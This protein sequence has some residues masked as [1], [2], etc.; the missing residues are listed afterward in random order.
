M[1]PRSSGHERMMSRPAH[2]LRGGVAVGL[3]METD[4]AVPLSRIPNPPLTGGQQGPPM[5][6]DT[7]T[8]PRTRGTGGGVRVLIVHADAGCREE[9][10]RL[11]QRSD[12]EV[13]DVVP[14]GEAAISAAKAFNPDLV[15]IGVGENQPF[16]A[17]WTTRRLAAEVPG[18]R[19][20]IF[21]DSDAEPE[22]AGSL[23]D[24][25]AG[26]VRV[27]GRA[28]RLDVT[29]RIAIAL[30]AYREVARYEDGAA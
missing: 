3:F 21:G 14:E 27:D 16:S 6:A 28:E 15:L 12:I 11:L 29:V 24:G 23:V 17:G 13:V 4:A 2:C 10:G 8:P 30:I 25:A 5:L 9:V 20:L 7:G 18:T 1:P 26:Y 19:V 22:L